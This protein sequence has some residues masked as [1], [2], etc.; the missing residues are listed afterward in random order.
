MNKAVN[1]LRRR[2]FVAISLSILLLSIC[3]YHYLTR[4]DINIKLLIVLSALT[5]LISLTNEAKSFFIGV[6]KEPKKY[7]LIICILVSAAGGLIINIAN[8]VETSLFLILFFSIYLIFINRDSDLIN[9]VTKLVI[10][11]GV[12]MSVG[13]LTGLFESTFL[14]SKLFYHIS[15]DY[16]SISD[17]KYIYSGF[18]F[19]QN[20]SALIK[21]STY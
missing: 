11:S 9:L 7:F 13:V 18:G 3:S 17:Q 5:V 4:V 2:P 20:Y 6:A 19:T 16:P 8:I 14:P 1:T 12:F 21:I 10:C 15:D